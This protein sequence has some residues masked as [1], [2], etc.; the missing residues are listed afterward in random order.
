VTKKAIAKYKKIKKFKI[1]KYFSFEFRYL[2]Q[3][4]KNLEQIMMNK[5]MIWQYSKM[6]F[7]KK[8]RYEPKIKLNLNNSVV[9]VQLLTRK[10]LEVNTKKMTK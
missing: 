4:F 7:T 3:D 6:R 8:S 1:E 9:L 10:E 5:K 2:Q